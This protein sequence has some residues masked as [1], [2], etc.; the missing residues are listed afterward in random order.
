MSRIDLAGR[1]AALE[2]AVR[3]S[4][5]RLDGPLLD[6]ARRVVTRAHERGGLSAEHTVVALAGA[7]G[8]GK[9]S[10]FNAVAGSDLATPGVR[11][12]TTSHAMAAVWGTGAGPLLDW[13]DVRVRHEMPV[14]PEAA[15]APATP[16][17]GVTG[18]FRRHQTPAGA[19]T[20]LV[21]LD[22]PDHD[23]VVVEHRV[24]AE[25]LVERADL[26]VWVVDPQKYA[27][28]ALHERYL[29]PLAGR[30][31]VVVVVLNQ[32]D[33]LAPS[34]AEAMRADL[35]RLV[36]ADGLAGARVVTASART[37][38]GI[39]RLRDL[40]AEAAQRREAAT[41]RL[42]LD[43]RAVAA[44]LLTA[45]GQ[46]PSERA[47]DKA[48]VAL[49]AALEDAAGV[50]VVTEAV[51][52]AAVKDA[53][54]ATGW[55]LTRWLGRLRPDPLRRIG[56]RPDAHRVPA[57]RPDLAVTSLPAAR[58]GVRAQS[59]TAVRAY[60]DQ[61][62]A[63][64]PEPWVLATRHRTAEGFDRLPDALDQA[65]AGTRLEAGRRPLWW[66][67]ANVLQWLVLLTAVA[68]LLWLGLAF[69]LAY[70]QL[71]A[72]PT[73]VLTVGGADWGGTGRGVDLPWATVLVVLGVVVGILL[74]LVFRVCAGIGARRRAS[75]ARKRLRESV[76]RV[77]DDLVRRPIQEEMIAL[78]R[79][80]TAAAIAAS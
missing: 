73:P 48:R 68:G 49:H 21:L 4:A 18:L 10:V 62:T 38:E 78:A 54:Q 64:A 7:T 15:T 24:R 25:R 47:G 79:A 36:A 66:R 13:L 20:G 46:S 50:P 61:M 34:D 33:R 57:D 56:L 29:R 17:R 67:L 70:F 14:G 23:S 42:A 32:V 1:T 30:G 26:L 31:D 5:G 45:C 44:R 74:A 58:A 80:R 28:A 22:L 11:R 65:V 43:E 51:R 35:E 40:L 63:G 37:G 60:V 9:S 76:A 2:A 12:P 3:E 77:A 53:R 41:A 69:L 19:T 6:E 39:D 52:R 71:P 8:S 55:P 72:L 75:A 27:D 16:A 59:A